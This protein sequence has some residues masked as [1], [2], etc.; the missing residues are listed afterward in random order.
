M[1]L[2]KEAILNF[3]TR[4]YRNLSQEELILEV[5]Y[6]NVLTVNGTFLEG[7]SPRFVDSELRGPQFLLLNL[8]E[9][10][11]SMGISHINPCDI[12]VFLENCPFV[13]RIFID[14]GDSSFENGYYWVYHAKEKFEQCNPSF[15]RLKII[16]VKGFKFRR[17]E[18]EMV[19]FFLEKARS[20]ERLAL[21]SSKNKYPKFFSQDVNIYELFLSWGK[22]PKPKIEMF[23]R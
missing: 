18:I 13:E 17:L 12:V 15:K 23:W 2:L 9:F 4:S 16:E 22:S 11:L 21:V 3:R 8:K 1:Q 10:N 19:K 6:V 5:A 14:L 7:L 20:L